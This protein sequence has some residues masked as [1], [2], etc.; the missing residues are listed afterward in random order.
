MGNND[1]KIKKDGTQ[2]VAPDDALQR[3]LGPGVDINKLINKDKVQR[4]QK[5]LEK[6]KETF[7]AVGLQHLEVINTRYQ[8]VKNSG[9]IKGGVFA[10]LCDQ[11]LNL[12]SAA[13]IY[14]Y[15]LATKVARLF[16]EFLINIQD[17]NKRSE[18]I[19]EVHLKALHLIFSQKMI[20]DG[21]AQGKV[22]LAELE[23]LTG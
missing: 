13:G 5:I 4:A 8:E 14:D 11:V 22:L 9:D 17:V 6:D 3:K 7:D 21:G 18:N 19:I 2:I 20:K 16:Y 10:S 1:I 15:M 12:K 23:K